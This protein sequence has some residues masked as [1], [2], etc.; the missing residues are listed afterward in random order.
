LTSQST[1]MI[2]KNTTLYAVWEKLLEV[3]YHDGESIDTVYCEKNE[4]L[5]LRT[6]YKE[7][8]RF[9]GW[10]E[11]N[12]STILSDK[13]TVTTDM[14]L[15]AQWEI[16]KTETPASDIQTTTD[17]PQNIADP[18]EEMETVPEITNDSSD[19][20]FTV[21]TIG[22]GAAVAAIVST[23]LIVQLRRA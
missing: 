13:L 4:Q 3:N 20:G 10:N 18:T 8:F 14:D 2:V 11:K 17:I 22:I 12:S 15:Y 9:I 5:A 1:K 16:V 6:S 19:N 23:I 21:T 7:G